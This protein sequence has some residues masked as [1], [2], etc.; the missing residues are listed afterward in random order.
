MRE[1]PILFNSEMVNALLDGH[2]TQ[3]RRIVK[4]QPEMDI[5]AIQKVITLDGKNRDGFFC[6]G[7]DYG[8]AFFCP[9]GQPG[10]LIWVREGCSYVKQGDGSIQRE[11]TKYKAD[12]RWSG[13]DLIK[14]KPSIHMPKAIARIWLQVKKIELERLQKITGAGCYC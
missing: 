12:A 8:K 4:P 14:W 5:K 9:Y 2:K 6:A 1:I 10:D 3:T 13:N 11:K 7:D